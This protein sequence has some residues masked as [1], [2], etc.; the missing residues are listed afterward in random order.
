MLLLFVWKLMIKR[1][2]F[3]PLAAA[4]GVNSDTLGDRFWRAPEVH[5][6]DLVG[7][8]DF[9]RDADFIFTG[10]GFSHYAGCDAWGC[11]AVESLS[12]DVDGGGSFGVCVFEIDFE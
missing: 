3:F 10:D 6:V 2:D 9:V 8:A 4:V 11:Y 1:M 12:V 7:S 5:D